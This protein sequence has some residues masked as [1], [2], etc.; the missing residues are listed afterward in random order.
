MASLGGVGVLVLLPLPCTQGMAAF[1]SFSFLFRL[2]MVDKTKYIKGGSAS[3]EEDECAS[4]GRQGEERLTCI[5]TPPVT[6]RGSWG[7]KEG[8]MSIVFL[9]L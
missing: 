7:G 3:F 2:G 1:F 4:E 6:M 8:R 9:C 5:C